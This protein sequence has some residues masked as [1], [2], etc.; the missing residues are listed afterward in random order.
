MALVDNEGNDV[1]EEEFGILLYK[2]GAVCG[3]GFTY[4]AADVI[5]KELN[6]T[7]CRSWNYAGH[8]PSNPSNSSNW[9]LDDY[10][11]RLGR[12]DCSDTDCSYTEGYD[13]DIYNAV[14]MSCTNS[15]YTFTIVTNSRFTC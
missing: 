7:S 11:M 8:N 13:C 4:K 2:G 9:R 15:G 10:P 14:V 3:S 12:V 1:E 6:F 5:C